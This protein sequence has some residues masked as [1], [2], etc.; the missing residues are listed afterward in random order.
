[1]AISWTKTH[2]KKMAEVLD[3]DHETVEG[4]AQA[5][6][7]LAKKLYEERAKFAVVGQVRYSDGWLDA[8]D[9]RASKV[10]MGL[11]ATEKQAQTAGESFAFSHQTGE[12]ARWWC[13]KLHNG[14]PHDWYK[15]RKE[16]RKVHRE[17]AADRFNK[18]FE[19]REDG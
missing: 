8:E 7:E 10:V 9:G 4:A 15:Q 14:T 11:F 2:E 18:Q 5:A 1:M 19:K 12:E 6:L 3:Q 13:V 16:E 17:T